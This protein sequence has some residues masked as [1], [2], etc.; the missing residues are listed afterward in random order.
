M[1]SG[2]CHMERGVRAIYL[3]NYRGFSNQF[4]PLVGMN[5]LVGENSTGKSSFLSAV[6]V[7]GSAKFWLNPGFDDPDLSFSSFSEIVSK[8]AVS[9]KYFTIGYY[10]NERPRGAKHD[11][12]RFIRFKNVDGY[13]RV[14]KYSFLS[15]SGLIVSILGEGWLKY[16][17]IDADGLG[18]DELADASNSEMNSSNLSGY[19]RVNIKHL[20]KAMLF[21]NCHKIIEADY[22]GRPDKLK[23]M[24]FSFGVDGP[25]CKWIAPIRTKPERIYLGGVPEYS[26][27]GG[28]VPY[29]LNKMLAPKA[30]ATDKEILKAINSFGKNS[31]LF[32]EVKVKKF[33]GDKLSPFEVNVEIDELPLLLGNVGYGVSQVLPVIL[34]SLKRNFA[35]TAIQQPE[36]HLHPRAQAALGEFLFE[37]NANKGVQYLVETHSDF[38]ID[39]YRL[40]KSK[41]ERKPR[42]Q[43]LFFERSKGN[44]KVHCLDID[45]FGRYPEDQPE[46]FR[47]FFLNEELSMLRV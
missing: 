23:S 11:L 40:C 7:L 29:L 18:M 15:V 32:D 22:T 12:F 37:C 20:P 28:H 31:G 14:Y 34:E 24:S 45:E 3:D 9:K 10:G 30:A 39:R 25:S 27:E 43:V 16:K 13:P 36:V 47:G 2:I 5:F 19:K 33:G 17:V 6:K 21:T 1:R 38:L 8:G 35:F 41:S 44:N 46:A 42:S 26:A 4:V